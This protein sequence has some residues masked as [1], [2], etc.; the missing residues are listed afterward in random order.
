MTTDAR[1]FKSKMLQPTNQWQQATFNAFAQSMV[2]AGRDPLKG[3]QRFAAQAKGVE[4][5][6]LLDRSI[7][8]RK[9]SASKSAQYRREFDALTPRQQQQQGGY[10]NWH[11]RREMGLVSAE[12]R[13]TK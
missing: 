8:P 2:E 5:P 3:L 7:R 13:P 11:T 4:R 9:A 10:Q 12:G 6:I 1:D